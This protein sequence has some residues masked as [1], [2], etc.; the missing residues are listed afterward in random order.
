MWPRRD[1]LPIISGNR[2]IL[3]RLHRFEML[4]QPPQD[5]VSGE[6]GVLHSLLICLF[7]LMSGSPYL[8]CC[9]HSPET[10]LCPVHSTM[11][12]CLLFPFLKFPSLGVSFVLLN[13]TGQHLQKTFLGTPTYRPVVFK[14][15]PAPATGL[16]PGSLLWKQ[17][18]GSNPDLLNQ[19]FWRWAR[20]SV[21]ALS[22]SDMHQHLR[23]T[24]LDR[25]PLR[26]VSVWA[27]THLCHYTLNLDWNSTFACLYTWIQ[28]PTLWLIYLSI[29]SGSQKILRKCLLNHKN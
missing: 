11:F 4:Q 27:S 7:S 18:L 14:M 12:L 13:L 29:H 3:F 2:V 10:L 19:V 8:V 25:L 6:R 20:Q 22:D 16:L 23:I 24:G 17:T 5:W 1:E 21:S 26:C 15:D 9:F 28:Q